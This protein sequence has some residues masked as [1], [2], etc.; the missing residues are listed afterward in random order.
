MLCD[1]GGLQNEND[2]MLSGRPR[3]QGI[4]YGHPEGVKGSA[5]GTM[6]VCEL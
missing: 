2:V 5:L 1:F 6:S 3:I 4:S